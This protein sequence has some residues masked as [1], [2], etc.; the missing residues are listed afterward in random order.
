MVFGV[1]WFGWLVVGGDLYMV[2]IKLLVCV[3]YVLDVVCY[4]WL[5]ECF[6]VFCMLYCYVWLLYEL[7]CV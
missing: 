4:V 7:L 3:E 1:V 6:D 5:C 2:L